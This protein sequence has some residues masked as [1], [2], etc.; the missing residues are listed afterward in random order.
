MT[1]VFN[2]IDEETYRTKKKKWLDEA[3]ERGYDYY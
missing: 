3:Q 1:E 2:E